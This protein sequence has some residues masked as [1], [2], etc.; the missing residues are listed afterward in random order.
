MSR[1]TSISLGGHFADFVEEQVSSGQYATTSEVIR[2]GLRLLEEDA[3]K[4]TRLR[5][6]LEAGEASGFT[7]DYSLKKVLDAVARKK[8]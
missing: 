7:E 2:A 5:A 6:A 8:R 3:L 1:T 4:V